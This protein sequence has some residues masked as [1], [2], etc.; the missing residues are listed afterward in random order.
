MR[1][2]RSHSPQTD[3]GRFGAVYAM[4]FT[5]CCFCYKL[6]PHSRPRTAVYTPS[7]D[8]YKVCHD[9]QLCLWSEL[10]RIWDTWRVGYGSSRGLAL[11]IYPP[12]LRLGC[13]A[14]LSLYP[15][16]LHRVTVATVAT[17]VTVALPDDCGRR[18]ESSKVGCRFFPYFHKFAFTHDFS[19]QEK[20]I[21]YASRCAGTLDVR[22]SEKS[23]R[24]GRNGRIVTV[25]DFQGI[26][27]CY[28]S[29]VASTCPKS[30]TK[31]VLRPAPCAALV[32]FCF[33][34]RP[35]P[36]CTCARSNSSRIGPAAC[37]DVRL[38]WHRTASP[39]LTGSMP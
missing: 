26:R 39:T 35:P 25:V 30:S 29:G 37:E 7:G 24:N 32:L 27:C 14:D 4:L 17:V 36:R 21:F 6:D 12:T 10:I 9:C 1:H 18:W 16:T 13:G 38:R 28:H 23:G 22:V 33:C 31:V 2:R 34:W 11:S 3:P 20:S 8:V 19:D 15:P 5:V